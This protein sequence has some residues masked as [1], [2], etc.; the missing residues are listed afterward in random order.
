MENTDLK[1]TLPDENSYAKTTQVEPVRTSTRKKSIAIL[2]AVMGGSMGIHSFYLGFSRK[3]VI[4]L[5][6]AVTGIS[7][8]WGLVDLFH[9]I[10]SSEVY[11]ADGNIVL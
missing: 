2:F 8:F 3:G 7:F 9:L 10:F 6:L 4:Q 11:D 5:L 1:F